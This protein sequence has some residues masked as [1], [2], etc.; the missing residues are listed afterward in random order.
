MNT[1]VN[2][3]RFSLHSYNM[4][5]L[6]AC[7]AGCG[8]FFKAPGS[9]HSHLSSAKSCAWYMKGKRRDLDIV[10]VEDNVPLNQKPELTSGLPGDEDWE[11]YDL[12]N[13]PDLDL[14]LGDIYQLRN[15]QHFIP[16]NP[17]LSTD[18]GLVHRPQQIIYKKQPHVTDTGL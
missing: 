6:Y 8:K 15:D 14:D 3:I 4:F 1:L 7:K 17:I 11:M 13:D 9:M 2:I 10:D 18:G 5:E 12:S 16:N